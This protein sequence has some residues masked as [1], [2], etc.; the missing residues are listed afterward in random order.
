MLLKVCG[1]R[2][3]GHAEIEMLAA[4]GVDLVGLWHAVP[5]GA[6]ELT[7]A[8]LD[9]LAATARAAA[10]EPVLVTF[11]SRPRMLA[12]AIARSGVRWVQLHAY[13]LPATVRA[14]KTI[15]PAGVRVIKVLHVERRGCVDGRLVRSYERAGVD[16][17]LLDRVA[18]DGRAD[19][20]GGSIPP[21]LA[22]AVA[23]GL[24]RPFMLAGGLSARNRWRY[25]SLARH[26]RFLG[27]DVS[28]GARDRHSRLCARSVRTLRRVWSGEAGVEARH[29]ALR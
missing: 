29:V 7:S 10:V 3:E 25:A 6:A 23:D 13:Q 12:E 26:E 1:V 27:I 24:A 19:S 15:A 16:V 11:E 28:T 2:A 9:R 22:S 21:E 4:A 8:E 5:G 18:A 20:G 14:L 17:F